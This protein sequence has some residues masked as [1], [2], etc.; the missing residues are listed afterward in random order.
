MARKQ[1]EIECVVTFT[2]GY[3]QRF[4]NA[5]LEIYRQRQ[6][7]AKITDTKDLDKEKTA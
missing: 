4:T 2:E 7:K 5:L 6:E 3:E 1:R